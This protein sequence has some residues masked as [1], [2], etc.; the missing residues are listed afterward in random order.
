MYRFAPLAALLT[1]PLNLLLT[2][3][4]TAWPGVAR[5]APPAAAHR[6]P[7]PA[8]LLRFERTAC[9]GPCPVD[10]LT[11]FADGRMRYQGQEHGPRTGTY[12]G[13]LRPAEL[14]ALRQAF[15]AARFFAFAPAYTS[16]ALDLPTY[17]LRYATAGRQHQVQDYDGAPPALKALEARLIAL[18]DAPNRWQKWR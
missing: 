17:Y 18:I 9:Y 15:A 13:R 2:L 10:V 12:A 11:I 4:L 14:L 1:L 5:P 8:L 6:R 3:L 7:A 16:A